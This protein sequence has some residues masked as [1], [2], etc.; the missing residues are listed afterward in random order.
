[1]MTL[2]VGVTRGLQA[3]MAGMDCLDHLDPRDLQVLQLPTNTTVLSNV[4]LYA[5]FTQ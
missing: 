1:M 4:L 2:P 5:P 3:V